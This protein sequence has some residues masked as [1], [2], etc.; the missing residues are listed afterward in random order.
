MTNVEAKS[1]YL[2]PEALSILQEM[3]ATTTATLN[4][5]H[6]DFQNLQSQHQGLQDQYTRE[7]NEIAQLRVLQHEQPRHTSLTSFVNKPNDFSG[8]S[9]D[10]VPSFIGHVELYLENVPSH[11]HLNVAVSYLTD[12][13]FNWYQVMKQNGNIQSW[14]HLKGEL[15]M[16]FN[17]IN[18]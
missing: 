10:C 6:Q 13:T 8:K 2:P 1:G 3:N 18:K 15:K 9:E 7:Q 14:E 17:P 11:Q 4:G 5:L 12:D 16:R